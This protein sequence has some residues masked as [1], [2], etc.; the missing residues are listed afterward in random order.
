MR[1]AKRIAFFLLLVA[2]KSTLCL[3]EIALTRVYQDDTGGTA[4]GVAVGNGFAFVSNNEGVSI[5]DIG[6]PEDPG[7]VTLYETP[8]G[9]AFDLS[10][11][12]SML[13]VA[14]IRDGLMI[15]DVANP[16]EPTLLGSYGHDVTCAFVHHQ[17]AF[18]C[19]MGRSMELVDVS[20]PAHPVLI[21]RFDWGGDLGFAASGDI[22]YVTQPGR[23]I[24]LLDVAD[25]RTIVERGVIPNTL[26]AY[27]LEARDGTLYVSQFGQGISAFDIADPLHPIRLVSFPNSGEAYVASGVLPYICVADLQ[28]GV[29]V[30]DASVA[31]APRLVA[32]ETTLAPHAV[33]Y[34]DGYVHVAD[35]DEG[36][37]VL[38]LAEQSE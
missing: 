26:T 5:Y 10:I 14:A 8:S 31:S 4:Y 6:H 25:P 20:D 33:F 34:A 35:Q 24:V 18:V 22:V 9:G 11:I 38:R 37:V 15:L 32:R 29:E 1:H 19:Q 13:Y 16:A 3:A 21:S 12:D 23:G 36:Y 7:F 17:M 30:I 27:K 2:L 28:E